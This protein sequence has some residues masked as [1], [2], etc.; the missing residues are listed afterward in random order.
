MSTGTDRESLLHRL[1]DRDQ[2]SRCLLL[3]CGHQASIGPGVDDEVCELVCSGSVVVPGA[4]VAAATLLLSL[5][6]LLALLSKLLSLRLA[7][8]PL[9][10]L[11]PAL[12]R[13][14]CR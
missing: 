5:L 11:L 8:R 13:C 7:L 3:R 4:T 2:A 6:L 12:L 9:L 10:R 14:P 1:R